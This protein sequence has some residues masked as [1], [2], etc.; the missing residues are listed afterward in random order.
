[1][2]DVV[3][4]ENAVKKSKRFG[5]DWNYFINYYAIRCM[6]KVKRGLGSTAHSTK[7]SIAP[8]ISSFLMLLVA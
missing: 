4:F 7:A 8:I 2:I 3:K 5:L 6:D 1:M